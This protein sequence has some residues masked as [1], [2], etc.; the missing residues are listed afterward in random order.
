[1][2]IIA[3][4]D[5]LE[6]QNRLFKVAAVCLGLFMLFS[7]A[8]APGGPALRT[9]QLIV[10]DA[11]GKPRIVL[12]MEKATDNAELTIL[13]SKNNKVAHLYGSESGA[14]VSVGPIGTEAKMSFIKMSEGDMRNNISI[15]HGK[16]Y[17]GLYGTSERVELDAMY[18]HKGSNDG[19]ALR[20]ILGV[21]NTGKGRI[22]TF[23]EQGKV[24]I[25]P[26][27]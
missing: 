2:D 13:D 16:M 24:W 9:R 17:C 5:R 18:N 14:A 21:G 19:N 15:E 12:G 10:E 7:G 6:K 26:N 3:R 20:A 22:A 27:R 4:L 11:D 25:S 23:D 1:M 8:A